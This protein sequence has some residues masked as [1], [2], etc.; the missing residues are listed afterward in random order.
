VVKNFS[1]SILQMVAKV[2]RENEAEVDVSGFEK[3][4]DMPLDQFVEVMQVL[5][6]IDFTVIAGFGETARKRLMQ[7]AIMQ[8]LPDVDEEVKKIIEAEIDKSTPVK[9][10]PTT[11][12]SGA[13][14]KEK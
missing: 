10:Q 2:R 7:R 4:D 12:Q 13:N 8:A 11:A 5:S 1:K 9:P 3:L 14:S 6:T